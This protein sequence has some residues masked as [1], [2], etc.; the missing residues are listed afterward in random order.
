MEWRSMAQS[1]AILIPPVEPCAPPASVELHAP[2]ASSI[3]H[4]MFVYNILQGAYEFGG[5][6]HLLACQCI[7]HVAHMFGVLPP[8]IGADETLI[9][10]I[11][12]VPLKSQDNGVWL[13]ESLADSVPVFSVVKGPVLL[14]AQDIK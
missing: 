7:W 11:F 3:H 2:W 1:L 14:G 6:A 12:V 4:G 5:F 10:A 13:E 9:G 8:Q